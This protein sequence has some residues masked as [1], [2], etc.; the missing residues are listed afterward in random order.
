MKKFT[1]TTRTYKERKGRSWPNSW[2]VSYGF[3]QMISMASAPKKY[4]RWRIDG[5]GAI[6]ASYCFSTEALGMIFR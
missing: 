6:V 5:S 3:T 2:R 1:K 4:S